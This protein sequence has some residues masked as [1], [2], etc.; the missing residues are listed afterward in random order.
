MN[1]SFQELIVK[2]RNFLKDSIRKTVDFSKT[3]QNRG[4]NAPPI[5]KPY[6]K[7]ADL[8]DLVVEEEWE[9]IFNIPLG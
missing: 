7:N 5:Q 3:E 8:I 1:D 4:I 2:N 6:P 9:N